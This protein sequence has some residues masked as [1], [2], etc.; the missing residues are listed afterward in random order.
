MFLQLTWKPT[1]TAQCFDQPRRRLAPHARETRVIIERVSSNL[2]L[3]KPVGYFNPQRRFRR[4][5]Q[6][7]KTD[8]NAIFSLNSLKKT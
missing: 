2:P 4:S 6:T 1:S 5:L 7:Y 8:R 3:N